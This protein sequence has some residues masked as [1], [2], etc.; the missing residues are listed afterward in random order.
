MPCVVG[1]YVVYIVVY[2]VCVK[3]NM[4]KHVVC[5]K[6]GEYALCMYGWVG[7]L[8]IKDLNEACCVWCVCSGWW[9]FSS[10]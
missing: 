6:C 5:I 4:V 3:C 1:G 7:T 8:C 2:V 9:V 10:F